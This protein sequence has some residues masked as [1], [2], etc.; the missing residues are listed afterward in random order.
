MAFGSQQHVAEPPE[1]M[2]ADRFAL[3]GAGHDGL[4]LVD[5]EMVRPEPHQ[6]LDKADFGLEG[7]VDPSP[8][9]FAKELPRQ[10]HRLGLGRRSLHR[11]LRGVWARTLFLGVAL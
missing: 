4:F 5:A 3:I 8:G 2:W 7:R 1:H 6:P 11:G 9:F 10:R